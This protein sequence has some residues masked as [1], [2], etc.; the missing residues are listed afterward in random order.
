MSTVDDAIATMIA[1]FPARTG[2]PLDQWVALVRSS[3]VTR[4]GEIVKLLKADHGMSHG[5]AN[6]VALTA[7]KPADAAS[8]DDLVEAMYAGP[9]A[10]LR[11]LH[12]AAVSAAQA[13]GDDVE[14]APKKA[15]VSLRRA[16]QFATIGPGPGGRLEI[17]LNLRGVE[18]AGR[19]EA[20]TGMCTHR[21]R[22]AP[23]DGVDDEV[24]GW[25]RQAYEGA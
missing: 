11:P 24:L 3:G 2:R 23:P 15:Y 20:T 17:G 19:L 5:F 13:F 1:N 16:K 4:H 21:V 22:V 9:K 12:D 14:L 18:P 7:L 8:G 6:Q 10:S 25:L